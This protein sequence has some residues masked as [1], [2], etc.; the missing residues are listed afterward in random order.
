MEQ[1]KKFPTEIIDLPS[2]GLLY[3]K[4][5]P[6][7]SGKV[8]MKYMTAKEEDILTNNNYIS[9]GIVIDKL[10]QAL[11]VDKSIKYGD[12]LAGDKNVLLVG[13]RILG[14]GEIYEFTYGGSKHTV[15]LSKLDNKPIDEELYKGSNNEFTFTLPTTNRNLTFK[16][17]THSDELEIDAEIKGLQKINKDTNPEMSTRLKHIITSVDGK[18]D[19]KYIRD[20]VDNEFLA[21]DAR[22]FRTYYGVIQPDLDLTFYP[23]GGPEE[24][25][26]I[27]IGINFLWPDATL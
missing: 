10:I 11:L 24:G 25:V 12:L 9:R 2:K 19:N 1:E 17:L 6:L 21:K 8:E 15:D 23:E 14:Y 27:P 13:A 4:E 20:F 5:S 3:P 22:A 7:S 26:D 18:T 16:L